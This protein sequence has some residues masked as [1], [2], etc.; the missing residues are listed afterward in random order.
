[1]R[2][3]FRTSI[4]LPPFVP[5]D[6]GMILPN[7]SFRSLKLSVGVTIGGTNGGRGSFESSLAVPF[8][9]TYVCFL[10]EM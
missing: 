5:R 8:Y 2:T 7:S 4:S 10:E 6:I 3:A 1:M 9:M